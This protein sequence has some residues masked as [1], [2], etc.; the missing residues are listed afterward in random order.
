VNLTRAVLA[1]SLV[2]LF[3]APA[4]AQVHSV[5]V[6]G[7]LA[8]D[9]GGL[10]V[11][12][13]QSGLGGGLGVRVA[14]GD[15]RAV[16]EIGA[17]LDVAGYTAEADGDPIFIGTA[18]ASYRGFSRPAPVR[19]YWTVGIGLGGTAIAGAGLVLPFKAGFGITMGD[20]GPAAVEIGV[21]DRFNLVLTSGHPGKD[22]I[23]SLGVEVALRFNGWY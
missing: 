8:Y 4:R 15:D 23:N 12:G 1:A 17:E 9:A 2:V 11:S 19:T 18:L 3:A 20:W 21:Y 13:T 10:F 14:F 22:Y 6:A 16:W 7:R 5:S